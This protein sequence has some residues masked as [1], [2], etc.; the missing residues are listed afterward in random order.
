MKPV[1]IQIQQKI[2][3][4]PY[5][6]MVNIFIW[7]YN[8]V[9]LHVSSSVVARSLGIIFISFVPL[10]AIQTVVAKIFP[11]VGHFLSYLNSYIIPLFISYGLI[12]YQ[13]KLSEGNS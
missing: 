13:Q 8:S 11:D 1:S 4:I 5:V 2:M 3:F 6:N 9:C 10:A 7:F 12:K